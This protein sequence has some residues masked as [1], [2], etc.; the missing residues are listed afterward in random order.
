MIT[1]DL[2]QSQEVQH[3]A[4]RGLSQDGYSVPQASS[5]LKSQGH[6]NSHQ[7]ILRRVDIQ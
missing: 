6:S 1:S 4:M 7:P 2:T 5:Q 3:I